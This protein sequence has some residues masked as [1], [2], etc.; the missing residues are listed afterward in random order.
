MAATIID[1]KAI[2]ATIRE[3]LAVDVAAF[4]ADSGITPHLAAAS[5][6]QKENGRKGTKPLGNR[7][8]G[9]ESVTAGR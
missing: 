7:L 1:G 8:V 2:A 3:E 6:V 9:S 5:P 4:H